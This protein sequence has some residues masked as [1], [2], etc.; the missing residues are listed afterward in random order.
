MHWA[1]SKV[2]KDNK[3]R[4]KPFLWPPVNYGLWINRSPKVHTLDSSIHPTRECCL[5]RLP[6]LLTGLLAFIEA[7]DS[8]T[9]YHCHHTGDWLLHSW[10]YFSQLRPFSLHFLSFPA[11][12]CC[13]SSFLYCTATRRAEP[14]SN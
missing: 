2:G 14:I 8:L 1:I 3:T 13:H 9:H 6:A 5:L 11:I 12:L 4:M 7:T 10:S